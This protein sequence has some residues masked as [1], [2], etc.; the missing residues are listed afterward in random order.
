MRKSSTSTIGNP[1]MSIRFSYTIIAAWPP[2]ATGSIA[3]PALTDTRRINPIRVGGRMSG[4]IY[5]LLAG[6][7]NYPPSVNG[8]RGCLNDVAAFE[9]IL[10]LRVQPEKLKLQ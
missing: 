9:E 10:K 4:L 3:L 6:I 1:R 5:A 2:R 7:D 8:L